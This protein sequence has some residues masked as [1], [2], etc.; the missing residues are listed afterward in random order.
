MRFYKNNFGMVKPFKI[1]NADGTA[2][3][4]T[5]LTITWKFK[6]R[7]N[8][9]KTL[10]GTITSAPN[11]QVSFTITTGFFTT[12]TRYRCQLHLVDGSAYV[13]DTDPFYVDID[14]VSDSA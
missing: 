4:L 9:L 6:D 14:E 10:T 3:S 12:V 2:K 5:G 11:G 8:T 1:L 7:D 13:E